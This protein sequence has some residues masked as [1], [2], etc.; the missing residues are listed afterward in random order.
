MNF[1]GFHKVLLNIERARMANANTT[2]VSR[3][4][5]S[6]KINQKERYEFSWICFKKLFSRIEF[7][8]SLGLSGLGNTIV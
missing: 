2:V 4:G 1:S 7:N 3:S 6:P 5:L 8:K